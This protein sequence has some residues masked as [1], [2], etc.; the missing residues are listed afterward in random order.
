MWVGVVVRL[1]NKV[2][3][4]YHLSLRHQFYFSLPFPITR[5]VKVGE[6]EEAKRTTSMV[7]ISMKRQI[8]CSFFLPWNTLH[9]FKSFL[10]IFDGLDWI[11]LSLYVV[12][13]LSYTRHLSSSYH[14]QNL[15]GTKYKNE[16]LPFHFKIFN[17]HRVE[18]LD[19]VL[20]S[21]KLYYKA[22]VCDYM[23]CQNNHSAICYQPF[24]V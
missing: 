10:K 20:N 15:K 21:N 14:C 5:W 4:I 9:F 23:N 19:F 13:S 7:S 8:N 1:Y 3:I 22:R 18:F 16:L 2:H 24:K 12:S 11:D 17:H 6:G